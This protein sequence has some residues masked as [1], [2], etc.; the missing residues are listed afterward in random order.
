MYDSGHQPGQH[1][2]LFHGGEMVCV[3]CGVAL[4]LAATDESLQWQ[5]LYVSSAS[6]SAFVFPSFLQT[7]NGRAK[8]LNI[9]ISWH[10]VCTEKAA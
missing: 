6:A 7:P 3:Y 4:W 9:F 2:F 8:G 10:F 1:D 5:I